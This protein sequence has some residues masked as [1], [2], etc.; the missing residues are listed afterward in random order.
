MS[1]IIEF[2]PPSSGV[3]MYGLWD[4]DDDCW[5]GTDKAPRADSQKSFM[6]GLALIVSK[7]TGHKV[8]CRELPPEK[9][10]HRGSFDT[11]TTFEEAAFACADTSKS[12]EEAIIVKPV[13]DR[14][15]DI[16][17]TKK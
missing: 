4:H 3:K 17:N 5:L 16:L 6:T 15:Q 9:M 12:R 14:V 13:F 11:E 2:E 7:Q 10:R 8:E 1:N